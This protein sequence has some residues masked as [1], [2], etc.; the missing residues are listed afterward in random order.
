MRASEDLGTR[1]QG[2]E[3]EPAKAGEK[4]TAK[5][6]TRQKPATEA[7]ERGQQDTENGHQLLMKHSKRE[8]LGNV[9]ATALP[10]APQGP[11]LKS[12]LPSAP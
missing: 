12:S 10:P 9:S 8:S 7:E 1:N 3:Q 2:G 6:R 11:G 5:D 4:P